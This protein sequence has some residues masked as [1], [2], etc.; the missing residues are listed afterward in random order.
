MPLT[1]PP[2]RACRP[3]ACGG[4]TLIE[5]LVA[6]LVL[7]I[8]LLGLAGLQSAG[9]RGNLSAI[10]RSMATQLADDIID[11]IRAN[12]QGAASY[13]NQ[14]GTGDDCLANLCS[15]AQT[16]GYDLT[17]WTAALAAQLP[18]G[19]G[20]V[21]LDGSPDDGIPGA[22]GCDGGGTTYTVKIWWDDN[23]TGNPET[24][25]RFTTSFAP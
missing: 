19:S 8:G 10:Q 9:L 13:D 3:A 4:F 21:C 14:A 22:A 20:T 11:R 23:R 1:H 15:A 24:F 12:A 18:S 6:A 5:V 25:Q 17:Q 7:G 2:F 16:A